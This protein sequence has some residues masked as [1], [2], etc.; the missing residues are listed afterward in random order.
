[1]FNHLLSPQISTAFDIHRRLICIAFSWLAFSQVYTLIVTKMMETIL[2]LNRISGG[3]GRGYDEHKHNCS[4]QKQF[5]LTVG[6]NE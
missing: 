2:S 4:K 6:K 3:G 5:T 1:M